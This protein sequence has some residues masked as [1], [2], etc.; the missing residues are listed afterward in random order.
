[1]ISARRNRL[2]CFSRCARAHAICIMLVV[3]SPILCAQGAGEDKPYEE[4]SYLSGKLRIQ[5]YLYKPQGPGPFP[6][7]IYN[8]GSRQG[9]ERTPVP[10]AYI[11]KMLVESGYV[12]LVPERRG[13]G[14][15]EGRQFSEEVGTDRGDRFVERMR[16]ETEDVLAGADYL[17]TVPYADTKRMGIMGWSLGGI[18]TIF[19]AGNSRLFQV[20][21][22]QAG[23][24]LTWDSSPAMRHALLDAAKRIEIPTL[25]MDAENDRSTESVRAVTQ[26][27]EKRKIPA[28]LI[29]YPPYTP[30]EPPGNVA[31]GHLI[32]AAPG[33]HLWEKDLKAF[34]AEHLNGKTLPPH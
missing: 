15:S 7:I 11:G 21:V 28:R 22:D 18:V 16:A 24:S 2:S 12:V 17:K 1:M 32:F 31:P 23:A 14:L 13:Y 19:A 10:F 5:A 4:V 8:H 9:R 27:L 26:E 6:V 33:A 29:I 20:A 30:P 3:L 34:L 25:A